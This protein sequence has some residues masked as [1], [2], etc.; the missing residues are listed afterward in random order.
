MKNIKDTIREFSRY[1]SAIFGAILI[2]LLFGL[3]VFAVIK[4]P[5]K[6]AVK[7]WRG[8]EEYVYKN[9]KNVPPE[10]YNY[11]TKKEDRKRVV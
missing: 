6:E 5:Y 9:P 10:W 1:P 4:I 3:A 11:F 2:L 7:L 8:G